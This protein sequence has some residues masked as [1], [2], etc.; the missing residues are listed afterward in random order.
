LVYVYFPVFVCCTKKN[1]ATLV[2]T[3]LECVQP[4]LADVVVGLVDGELA[5]ADRVEGGRIAGVLEA[6]L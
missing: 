3:F 5:G 2:K 6:I 4:E 1:L